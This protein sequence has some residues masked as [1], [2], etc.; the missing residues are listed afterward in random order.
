[1]RVGRVVELDINLAHLAGRAHQIL[2]LRE[3]HEKVRQFAGLDDARHGPV[4]VEDLDC[5]A[6]VDVALFG[7]IL[8]EENIGR[9]LEAVAFEE[10]KRAAQAGKRH[11][12][13]AGDRIEAAADELHGDARCGHDVRLL[14]R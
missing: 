14:A 5:L 4:L 9:F 1:M 10:N 3:Q 6:R 13:D 2:K 7:V 8:I 12:I 11:G